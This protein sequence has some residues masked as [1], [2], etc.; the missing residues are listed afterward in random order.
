MSVSTLNTVTERIVYDIAEAF[1]NKLHKIILYGSYARGDFDS[2]S[3]IDIM[4]L[5]DC[6]EDELRQYRP[7]IC[8][9]ASRAS[10]ESDV[11]VSILLR[12]K[13]S[14]EKRLELLNFYRNVQNEGVVLY[15]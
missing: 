6:G 11:E 4:V 5:L 13:A 3:D 15:G 9:I 2:E 7:Q 10:L 14:F 1:G 12:D 8:R